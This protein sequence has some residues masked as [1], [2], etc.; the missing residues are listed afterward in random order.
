MDVS[1][2][3]GLLKTEVKL[4]GRLIVVELIGVE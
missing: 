2:I 4:H 3:S 1:I